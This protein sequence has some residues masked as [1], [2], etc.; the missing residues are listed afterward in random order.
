MR[1]T[2][3]NGIAQSKTAAGRVLSGRRPKRFFLLIVLAIGVPVWGLAQELPAPVAQALAR[4]RLPAK[5][6][7]VFIQEVAAA[8]P[9]LV[10]N[11]DRPFSPASTIKLLTTFAALDVLGPAYTWTTDAYLDGPLRDGRLEGNLI[12]KGRGD[13][14]LV[15]EHFGRLV[16]GLR[17]KGL[18][19]IGGDL[20]IDNSF[21]AVP[22]E[23]P[24]AFDNKPLHPYNVAPEAL[25]LNFKAVQ[26]TFVPDN[27][28]IRITPNPSPANLTIDNRLKPGPGYCG[29]L[30]ERIGVQVS[31]QDNGS[32]VQFNGFY[33]SACGER[34]LYRVVMDSAALTFGVFK[35][36]WSELGGTLNDQSQWRLGTVPPRAK[37]FLTL[38]S[39]PLA[40][41]IQNVNKYSNNVMARHLLL[42]LGAKRYGPPGTVAKGRKALREWLAARQLNFPELVVDNGSGLSRK[43]R[44]SPRSLGR[45]LLAAQASPQG[46]KFM[47]SLSVAGRDG[48]LS[49]RFAD[50][51]LAGRLYGKTGTLGQVTGIAGYLFSRSD[52]RF[53]VVILQNHPSVHGGGAAVQ[54]ALLEWLFEQ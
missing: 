25:L 31:R 36:L 39:P 40:E 6:L 53:V 8:E 4:Y 29:D 17:D 18:Q 44:I 13:P 30:E 11:A 33:P 20:V 27:Q 51:P 23:N 24:A 34:A 42:T 1:R 38:R 10:F 49:R 45:L 41:V 19:Q 22:A 9:L 15:I 48:T 28:A 16:R 5:S 12:L 26:F 50:S 21:F 32:T 3:L 35:S 14:F 2:P 37:P 43:D 46:V 7:G 47:A 52:R 54:K